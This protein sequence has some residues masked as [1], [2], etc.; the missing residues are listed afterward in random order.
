M[1]TGLPARAHLE[2]HD[3]QA[4]LSRLPGGL[5]ARQPSPDY[6]HRRR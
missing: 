5:A 3:L 6:D 2:Q 4:A 1:G